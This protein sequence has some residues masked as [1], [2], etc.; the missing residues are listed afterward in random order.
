MADPVS[1][2][3]TVPDTVLSATEALALT[4]HPDEPWWPCAV[5]VGEKDVSIRLAG[6]DIPGPEAPWRAQGAHRIWIADRADL[7]SAAPRP[8]HGPRP[9]VIGRFR[10]R[11]IFI[12]TTRAP[13]PLA[14]VGD[15][16]A[17]RTLRELVS[18]QLPPA[19]S[20]PG[21]AG[22][23]LRLEV[24]DGAIRLLGLAVAEPLAAPHIR[25][26][27]ELRL[28]ADSVIAEAADGH[29]PGDQQ[30]PSRF[31][32]PPTISLDAVDG[33]QREPAADRSGTAPTATTPEPPARR[34]RA[35]DATAD[36]TD[37]ELDALLHRM[38]R[39]TQ[40]ITEPRLGA[41]TE[42]GP[43]AVTQPR[44][45]AD[46]E[47]GPQAITEPRL[48]ADTESGPHAIAEPGPRPIIVQPADA[49]AGAGRPAATTGRPRTVPKSPLRQHAQSPM[50]VPAPN[51]ARSVQTVP[52]GLFS[53]PAP[54]AAPSAAEP[55]PDPA[56]PRPPTPTT[57]D[58]PTDPDL[59][60]WFASFAIS[61]AE[62]Q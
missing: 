49:A 37:P 44:L 4:E 39:F 56:P 50:Q 46:T 22:A 15:N 12:S 25:S 30:A 35:A 26:A 29:T 32:G 5:A 36:H 55:V 8:E 28:R 41:D 34:D 13:G 59:E 47:P 33:R 14:V 11:L 6:R 2:L 18:R 54:D 62:D 17:A 16:D 51:P 23:F 21:P 45:R 19:R 60:D 52:T 40:A 31:E 42:S 20:G 48:R 1:R 3:L 10:D 7:R 58:T 57:P 38:D 43:Q 24:A 61:S 53:H 9:I 27:I